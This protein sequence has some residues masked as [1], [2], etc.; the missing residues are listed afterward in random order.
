MVSRKQSWQ[1]SPAKQLIVLLIALLSTYSATAQVG[2]RNVQV[3]LVTATSEQE[4]LLHVRVPRGQTINEA[5]LSQDDMMITLDADVVALEQT[6]FIVLDASD[7]MV[8]LQPVVQS[9]MPR[10]WQTGLQATSVLFFDRDVTVLRPTTRTEDID[11]FLTEYTINSGAPACLSEPLMALNDLTR[12]YDRSWRILLVTTGDFSGSANCDTQ[13]L[14][15]APAPI[16]VIA[17][18]SDI[19]PILQDLIDRSG[20]QFYTANL[21]SLEARTNDILAQWGQPSYVLAGDIPENWDRAAPFELD[22][23]LS[24]GTEE[25]LT[26]SFRD[27][28][29]PLPLTP[30]PQPTLTSLPA[31]D[32]VAIASAEATQA[33]VAAS[34][35]TIPTSATLNDTLLDNDGVAILLVIGAIFFVVGAVVL[36]LALSRVRRAPNNDAPVSNG[37]FYETLTKPNPQSSDSL[38]STRVRERNIASVAYDDSDTKISNFDDTRMMDAIN[39]PEEDQDNLLLTQVLTDDRFQSMMAQSQSNDE[40]IGW[41]RLVI[42]G[43]DAERDYELTRRGALVGRS[44]ECDIQITGDRAISRKHARLDVRNN[45][46]V[47]VSRLSAVNPVV[48]GGVQISNRHPLEPNDVIHLSDETRLIFIARQDELID[49]EE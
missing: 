40:V 5:T 47:T 48:V 16:D 24:N 17:I 25:T 36:A 19:D 18:T 4:A 7:A 41:M 49:N 3:E 2:N 31:T 33:I 43:V 13:A 45:D 1:L 15:T 27:Y 21:R 26:L 28:N 20:G 10:L 14:A 6:Q 37:N 42:E 8:N 30:T 35:T 9:N 38:S 46:Q 11:N 39:Q 22:I 29:V 44:L 12:D 34:A 32:V 23:A